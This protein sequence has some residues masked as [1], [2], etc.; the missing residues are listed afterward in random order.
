VRYWLRFRRRQW[1]RLRPGFQRWQRWHWRR[2]W[3]GYWRWL[4][5]FGPRGLRLRGFR[6]RCL[7]SIWGGVWCH[8]AGDFVVGHRG[9]TGTICAHQEMIP[10]RALCPPRRGRPALQ[11]HRVRGT[12]AAQRLRLLR[13][14]RQGEHER[15]GALLFKPLRQTIE[16][17]NQTFKSQLHLERHGRHTPAGVMV[18][19]L[20]R[21][22][23]L[24]AAIWHN[25]HTAAPFHRSLTAY[26]H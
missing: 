9:L 24:T 4:Y 23:A 11:R 8:L 10:S 15:P 7:T 16:S 17:I 12:L 3:R 1:S 6:L 5:R 25:D 26:D 14:A 22:L 21:I 18:R 19:I 13:P 20:Q 2:H